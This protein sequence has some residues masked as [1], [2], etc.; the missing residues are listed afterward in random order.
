M[1]DLMKKNDN[2]ELIRL[3]HSNTYEGTATLADGS[4]IKTKFRC[5]SRQEAIEQWEA[6]QQSSAAKNKERKKAPA[7]KQPA[8]KQPDSKQPAARN[9]QGARA[10]LSVLE[11]I[12]DALELIAL[13]EDGGTVE[14]TKEPETKQ[15][16][17]SA[18]QGLITFI[19]GHSPY[20]FIN[21]TSA[22]I[23]KQACEYC[24]SNGYESPT[25]NLVTRKVK[26]LCADVLEGR[27]GKNGTEFV[28][29]TAR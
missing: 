28:Y 21:C 12:A 23:H 6:W 7:A 26:E 20:E 5:S 19:K 8:I 27:S 29:K 13:R 4:V 16:K 22:S 17:K 3:D 25:Q 15:A 24:E 2:G 11:R 10:L 1:K 14:Q 9:E 18:E